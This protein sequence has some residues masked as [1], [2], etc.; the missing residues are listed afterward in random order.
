MINL[1][2]KPALECAHCGNDYTHL[3]GFAWYRREEDDGVCSVA[4]SGKTGIPATIVMDNKYNPSPRRDGMH[5]IYSCE[6]CGELSSLAIAQHKGQTHVGTVIC[7]P[8]FEQKTTSFAMGD[9]HENP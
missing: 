8:I 6:S 4:M 2:T 7:P 9:G 3:E 5:I 1:T